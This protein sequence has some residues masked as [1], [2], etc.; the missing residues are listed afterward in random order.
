MRELC[1]C[2]NFFGACTFVVRELFWCVNSFG[3]S[4]LLVHQ[5][6]WCV[7]FSGASSFLCGNIFS[8]AFTGAGVQ[9]GAI[10]ALIIGFQRAVFS[11]E[12]GIGSA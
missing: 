2:V 9:G 11:N 7:N 4:T 12:A 10:G 1:W 5:L 3:A 6:F 8:G